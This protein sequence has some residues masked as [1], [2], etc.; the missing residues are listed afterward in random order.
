M[1]FFNTLGFQVPPRKGV[2]D[3]L[4]EVTS[5]VDQEVRPCLV[6]PHPVLTPRCR[7]C[8]DSLQLACTCQEAAA[9]LALSTLFRHNATTG[10][11]C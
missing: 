9:T 11:Y 7:E 1:P 4:Q 6:N 3:F 5:R 8:H 2:A 10:S